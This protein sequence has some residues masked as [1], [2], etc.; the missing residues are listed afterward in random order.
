MRNLAR[1]L[2]LIGLGIVG[3]GLFVGLVEEDLSLELI[4]GGIGGAVFFVGWW[5]QKRMPIP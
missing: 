5:L 1:I 3:Y 4:I 2:Q